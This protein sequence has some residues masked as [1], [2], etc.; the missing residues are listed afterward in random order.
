MARKGVRMPE[1]YREKIRNSQILTCLIQHV[2]GKRK[3]SS[4]Q[5]TAGLGLLKKCLPDLS[6]V[7]LENGD[8]A[9]LAIQIVRFS[10]DAT[11][12]GDD[13]QAGA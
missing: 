2:E 10:E 12:G 13:P 6:S 7:S 11:D 1:E 3:M 5:V 9:P 4:S 8:D